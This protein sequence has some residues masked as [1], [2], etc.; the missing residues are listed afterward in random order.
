[1]TVGC[2]KWQCHKLYYLYMGSKLLSAPF[3]WNFLVFMQGNRMQP[4]GEGQSLSQFLIFTRDV[5]SGMLYMSPQICKAVSL[6]TARRL[7]PGWAGPSCVEFTCCHCASAGVLWVL[8]FPPIQ[9]TY[10]RL[11]LQSVFLRYEIIPWRSGWV[12]NAQFF[13]VIKHL[14]T[15]I[16]S[17]K[18]TILHLFEKIQDCMDSY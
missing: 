14:K 6:H 8:Q 10:I 1:M 5:K 7:N 11:I 13:N 17:E 12:K 18:T 2:D 15:T 3:Y 16:N 4:R 9:N